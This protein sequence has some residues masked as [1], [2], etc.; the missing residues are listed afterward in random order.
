MTIKTCKSHSCGEWV[1]R[2]KI[3]QQNNFKIKTMLN[4]KNAQK[5]KYNLRWSISQNNKTKNILKYF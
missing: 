5:L 3:L 1:T 4:K 2:F